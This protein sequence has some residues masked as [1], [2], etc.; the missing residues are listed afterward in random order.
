MEE[1]N[2]LKWTLFDLKKIEDTN[3]LMRYRR[4]MLVVVK[5]CVFASVALISGLAI[6]L[7]FGFH[8]AESI[9]FL[10]CCAVM[11]LTLLPSIFSFALISEIETILKKRHFKVD[12]PIDEIIRSWAVKM[13]FWAALVVLLPMLIRTFTGWKP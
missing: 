10:A 3:K 13:M 5:L 7:A 9:I 2:I 8:T 6:G 12:R 11:L 4:A 1:K